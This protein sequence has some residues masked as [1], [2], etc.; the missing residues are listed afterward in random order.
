MRAI[1]H[2]ARHVKMTLLQRCSPRRMR[3]TRSPGWDQPTPIGFDFRRVERKGIDSLPESISS[4]ASSQIFKNHMQQSEFDKFADEYHQM[5]SKSIRFSGE[6][7]SFFYEYKVQTAAE[8]ARQQNV[9]VGRILD[10]GAGVGNSVPFFSR[11][12]PEAQLICADVSR[13]SLDVSAERFPNSAKHVEIAGDTIPVDNREVD[14]VFSACVFHHIPHAEH[15]K[16]LEELRR[17]CRPGALLT[18]FEHNPWN[19]LTLRVVRDCPFDENAELIPS[20][21]FRR[22]L[23]QSGW[24]DPRIKFLLFFPRFLASLRPA[25]RLLERVPLGAQ[26]VASA[27]S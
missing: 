17:V 14:L 13:R 23:A 9:N 19:P 16:W 5:L 10:F 12:F 21:Q 1:S 24:S 3:F 26:Y 22:R 18:I 27:R 8:I 2:W 11:H 6:D 4:I 7:P 25:E 20:S 15:A